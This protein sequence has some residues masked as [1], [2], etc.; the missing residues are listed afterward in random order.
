[1]K[2]IHFTLTLLIATAVLTGCT[3]PIAVTN[4]NN[5]RPSTLIPLEE[6]LSIG[7]RATAPDL[8]GHRL[9]HAIRRDLLQYNA[10]SVMTIDNENAS[11]DVFADIAVVP[12]YKGS[13]WNFWAEFP[14]FLIWFPAWHGYN[15][16]ANYDIDVRLSDA[17]SGQLI[18]TIYIPVRLKVRHADI[19]RTW[20]DGVSWVTLGIPSLIG[21]LVYMNYDETVTPLVTQL[22]DPTV[23]DYVAQQ[24]ATK[25]H[26]YKSAPHDRIEK[27]EQLM[28]D[29]V[30]TEE[31]YI[32]KRQAII[33]AL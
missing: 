20:T 33:N 13:G 27:L 22:A 24:I 32:T 28:A 16:Q 4:L 3:H 12:E 30:I 9:I 15:Y 31:E 19:S 14:G 21:G 17:Q 7:V 2:A 8:Q 1:M 10:D 29:G 25:L 18:N 11:L 23:A 6:R 26:Y 5:Y